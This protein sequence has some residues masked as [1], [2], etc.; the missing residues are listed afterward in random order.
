MEQIQSMMLSER[1]MVIQRF[2]VWCRMYNIT[3]APDSML[4]WLLISGALDPVWIAD[5]DPVL[6]G[7][8]LVTMIHHTKKKDIRAV[9]ILSWSD[10]LWITDRPDDVLAWQV[11]P[12]AFVE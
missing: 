10:G 8:Y 7:D 12:D 3:P 4:D 9:H 1:K 2:M 6:D 5:Q 11:L